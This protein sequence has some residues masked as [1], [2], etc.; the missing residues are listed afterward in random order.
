MFGTVFDTALKYGNKVADTAASGLQLGQKVLGN[1]SK[2]GHKLVDP[3]SKGL[4]TISKVPGLGKFAK[5]IL[6]PAQA[7]V[8]VAKSGLGVVDNAGAIM[9]R[10]AEG[11]R[12][13]QS[14]IKAGDAHAGLKVLRDTAKDTYAASA[15]LKKS[16]RSAIE[17]GK[18]L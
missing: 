5:P 15:T 6:K 8:G 18:R 10:G 3:V 1:V 11:I 14:A 13:A 12:A 16:A 9:G 7:V 4:D 2:Y 17:S